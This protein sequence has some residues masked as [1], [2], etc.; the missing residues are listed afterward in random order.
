MEN[1]SHAG[2]AWIVDQLIGIRDKE[3]QLAAAL[4]SSDEQSSLLLDLRVA[5]LNLVLEMLDR[6]LDVYGE[7]RGDVH[8]ASV[9]EDLPEQDL[10]GKDLPRSFAALAHG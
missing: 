1:R 6:A 10:P 9:T 3:Q 4:A 7:P 2:C 8:A 5:E